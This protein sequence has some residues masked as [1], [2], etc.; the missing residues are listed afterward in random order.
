[1]FKILEIRKEK[2]KIYISIEGIEEIFM[3]D[4][5]DIKDN[6]DLKEQIKYSVECYI[7]NKEEEV[8]NDTKYTSLKSLE[9]TNA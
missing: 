4:L 6:A 2:E 1:M 3:F 5:K 8:I 9:G 7:N